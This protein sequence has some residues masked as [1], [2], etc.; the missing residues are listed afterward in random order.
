MKLLALSPGHRLHR[1]QIM[2]LLWPEL[3]TRAASNNLRQVLY[4]ARRI[5]DPAVGSRYLASREGSRTLPGR[6]HLGRRG[7][8]RRGRPDGPSRG[9]PSA[10]RRPSISTRAI[11]SRRT[12]TRGGQTGAGAN[13]ERPTCRFFSASLRPREARRPR[14]GRRGA[15]PGG[16]GGSRSR[17]Y[18]RWPDA[19]LRPLRTQGR[20]LRQYDELRN[21]VSRELGVE[22]S[23]SSRALRKR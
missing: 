14:L 1:E 20:G 9:E 5:L 6:G 19:P 8:L 11:C 2:D 16:V 10:T 3:G 12:V 4:A 13:F 18:P 23:A 7:C 22:P 17:G 15:A 21:T